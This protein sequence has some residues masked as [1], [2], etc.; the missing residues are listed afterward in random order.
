MSGWQ[1]FAS[2]P[3]DG[4]ILLAVIRYMGEDCFALVHWHE[5]SRAWRDGTE[6]LDRLP[7]HWMPLPPMPDAAA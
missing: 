6:A 7:H 1:D 3:R 2:A 5:R 4:T